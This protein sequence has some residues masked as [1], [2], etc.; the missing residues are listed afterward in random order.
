MGLWKD[1]TFKTWVY[2]FRYLGKKYGGRGFKTKREAEAARAVRREGV[3]A[4][5]KAQYRMTETGMNFSDAANEY[6]DDAVRR[7]APKTYKYKRYV[8]ASFLQHSGDKPIAAII[9]RDIHDYLLTR[10]SNHNA[11]V[12]RKDLS[13][14]FTWLISTLKLPMAN[15]CNDIKKLPHS[16]ARKAPPS[17]EDILRLIVAATPGDERDILIACLHTLGRIDEVL[18]LRWEDVN[19]DKQT[20]TLWTRKRR[21][22]SYEA[23]ALPMSP[24]LYDVLKAR[25]AEREQEEWVFYNEDTGTRFMHRPKMMDSICKRAGCEP[26]GTRQIKLTPAQIRTFEKKHKRMIQESEK[27]KTVPRYCGFH[28]LRHFMATYLADQEKVRMKTVQGLLRHKNLKTTEIY[29][30][31]VDE[32]QRKAVGQMGKFSAKNEEGLRAGA[33]VVKQ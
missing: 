3:K 23:D 13:A 11:N 4:E 31:P 14:L 1:K 15:P 12:H 27:F 17:E 22:S 20:V 19:F 29:L 9:P 26:I 2:E 32:N 24:E 10:P 25:F 8:Y 5:A 28:A 6:L 21:N 18:R 33:T 7:F 16:P 30:H